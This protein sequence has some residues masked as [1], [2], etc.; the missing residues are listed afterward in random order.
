VIPEDG[1]PP[2]GRLQ[3]FISAWKSPTAHRWPISVIEEGYKIQWSSKPIPWAARNYQASE[4]EKKHVHEAVR[5]FLESGVIE[6]S[7]S[8]DDRFLSN[9]FTIQEKDKVRPILDC[10]RINAFIQCQ[11]FEKS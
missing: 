3:H 4:M 8:E 10:K 6:R 2:G 5:K 11:H 1:I 9:L 7:P